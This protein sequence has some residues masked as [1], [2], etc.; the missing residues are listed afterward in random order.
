VYQFISQLISRNRE[1]LQD[2][3]YTDVEPAGNSKNQ[4]DIRATLT[5]L[6]IAQNALRRLELSGDNNP[7]PSQIVVVGP[8]QV[9]KSTVTNIL[10]QQ[11]LA[12]SSAEAGF[13]VH[14]QGFHIVP[15]LQDRYAD[16]ENWATDYFGE[17]K[18]SLQNTLDR[19]VLSEYSLQ[20]TLSP[21]SPLIDNVVW[22]TPDFDSIRSFDYRTPLIKV[23]AL[24]DLV[25]FVVSIDKYADKTVWIMLEL[26]ASLNTPLVMVMNKTPPNVQAELKASIE[27]KYA[28][29]LSASQISPLSFIGEYSKQQLA[30]SALL[31]AQE[32]LAD[33]LQNIK[34]CLQ[35]ASRDELKNKSLA[36]IRS[37][38]SGW[39]A[40][41]SAEHRM[42]TEYKVLVDTV[43]KETAQR[44]RTEYID[45]DRHREVIQLALSELLVLLEVPGMAKPLSKIRSVVTW[46]VRTLVSAAKEPAPVTD[47]DRNE[48]RRLLDELGKHSTATLIASIADRESGADG[49]WWSQMREQVTGAELEI[50]TRYNK[51]VDNYQTMLQVEID[52]AAQSLYQELQKQPATLNGLRAARVTADAAAV[53]LAV[54]SGGL[55]AVDLVVAPAMLSLTTLLTEGAL[56]KYMQ[57]VQKNLTAYQEKEV[58]SLI[59][60]KLG[61]PFIQLGQNVAPNVNISEDELER[62][63]AKL[64]AGN[65]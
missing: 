61:K 39:T 54:K 55:G 25:V 3:N 46:P 43:A 63:T 20:E 48:E 15:E 38:W 31:I 21:N 32:E 45:S 35:P 1:L 8:T 37:H 6:S 28:R 34:A 2:D 64:E 42:Q 60:R 29:V 13:T 17:L 65:V 19:Q 33:L 24:A 7:V 51:S 49:N 22:D 16:Q 57:R 23:L 59:N 12:E 47:D 56:G 11:R 58:R 62:M 9:G 5:T 40:G 52:R 4:S 14:C 18:H 26:L 27:K 53:V 36:F 44:Y 10:L 50:K 41:V 30:Q